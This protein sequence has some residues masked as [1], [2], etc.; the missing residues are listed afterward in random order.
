MSMVSLGDLAQSLMMR[1]Q[2]LQIRQDITRLAEEVTTG[3][4]STLS[5]H[6]LGD[7]SILSD[8]ER[9]LEVL[10]GF[11]TSIAEA[12]IFTDGMQKVLGQVQDIS[13]DFSTS[14]MN[15]ADND[16]P[17]HTSGLLNTG[18]GILDQIVTMLNTRIAGRSLFA[19]DAT[20]RPALASADTIMSEIRLAISGL[21]SASSI[22]SAVDT[23][24]DSPS[25]GFEATAYLGS[26]T[27]IS[28]YRLD[29]GASVDLDLRANSSALRSVLKQIALAALATD[30]TTPISAS[31]RQAMVRSSAIDLMGAQAGLTGLRA[32]LGF[33]QAR[34]EEGQVRQASERTSLELT[35][36]N[37]LAV[38]SYESATKLADAQMRLESLYAVTVRLSRLSLSDFMR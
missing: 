11:K 21:D 24:F 9:G 12:G 37:I 3:R 36:N 7:F 33:A 23:W 1:R 19:G 26:S 10:K 38:D 5:S 4:T 34:I 6:L 27:S 32:D 17:I 18:S 2:N 8:I 29:H 15:V 16:L 20:D 22:Q 25:A 31:D 13:T 28:P 14:L 30:P 35:R